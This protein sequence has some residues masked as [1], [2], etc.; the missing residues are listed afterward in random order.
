MDMAI[1]WGVLRHLREDINAS[2]VIPVIAICFNVVLLAGFSL[3]KWLS[4]PVILGV[5]LGIM[6]TILFVEKA[7]LNSYSADDY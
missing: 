4:D 7:F 3:S 5:A 6:A 2:P 1:Q